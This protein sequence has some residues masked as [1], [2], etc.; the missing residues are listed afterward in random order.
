MFYSLFVEIYFGRD[1]AVN[2]NEDHVHRLVQ[3]VCQGIMLPIQVL[4]FRW[5]PMR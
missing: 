4:Q 3:L 1:R 5:D 2:R